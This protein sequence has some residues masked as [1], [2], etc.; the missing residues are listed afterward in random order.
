MYV[1]YVCLCMHL[2]MHS[3]ICLSAFMHAPMYLFIFMQVHALVFLTWLDQISKFV[4][5]YIKC[6]YVCMFAC[7]NV[8]ICLYLL[9]CLCTLLQ[10]EFVV[11][12]FLTG[13]FFFINSY[14]SKAVSEMGITASLQRKYH[15]GPFVVC[16]YPYISFNS[17]TYSYI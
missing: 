3:C 6:I 9:I 7:M 10:L 12:K 5:M 11:W 17:S 15:F 4:C 8:Q 13:C 1:L 16:P 2:C 14:S